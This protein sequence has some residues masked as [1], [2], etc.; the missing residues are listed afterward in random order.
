MFFWAPH[1]GNSFDLH[2]EFVEEVTPEEFLQ[3]FENERDD[4]QSVI[5]VPSQFGDK[6]FGRILLRRK[7]PVYKYLGEPDIHEYV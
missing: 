3:I 1:H 4:I 2:P 6:K 5:V 7:R